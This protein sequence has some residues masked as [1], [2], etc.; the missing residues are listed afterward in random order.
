[1]TMK[2]TTL[3]IREPIGRAWRDEVVT[4]T[5]S[6]FPPRRKGLPLVVEA[7]TG[8]R[9]PAQWGEG[10]G[11][12]PELL[13]FIPELHAD[14]VKRLEWR[15]VVPAGLEDIPGAVFCREEADGR[16][17]MGGSAWMVELPTAQRPGPPI[18][19]FKG[20][21]GQWRGGGR[22]EQT[23]PLESLET[24]IV[25]SGPVQAEAQITWRWGGHKQLVCWVRTRMGI[26]AVE[27]EE[28]FAVAPA[29]A[30][31]LE[32]SREFSPD[33]VYL[34][35]HTGSIGRGENTLWEQSFPIDW[36]IPGPYRL[37][38]YH[39]WDLDGATWWACYD[40]KGGNDLVGLIMTRIGFWR[41]GLQNQ[42]LVET[43]PPAGV[44][45]RFPLGE[46]RRSWALF[47]GDRSRDISLGDPLKPGAVHRAQIKLS[48]LPLQKVLGWRLD[49]YDRRPLSEFPRIFLKPGQLAQQRRKARAS[50]VWTKFEKTTLAEIA[51]AKREKKNLDP[52]ELWGQE[53]IGLA[54]AGRTL[55][56]D[57]VAN[58]AEAMIRLMEDAV[59]RFLIRGYT[60]HH[61]VALCW[62]RYAR[63]LA[64][65]FDALAGIGAFSEDQLRRVLKCWNFVTHITGEEDYWPRE[66]TAFHRGNP[67]FH[68]DVISALGVMAGL[69]SDH[70]DAPAWRDFVASEFDKEFAIAI[71][72][73]GVWYES[74][75][76]SV[77]T[78]W[79]TT[80]GLAALRHTG[81][82]DLFKDPR[83]RRC[84]HALCDIMTP[85]DPRLKISTIPT[86][87]NSSI[88]ENSYLCLY[89]WLSAF[90][91]EDDPMLAGK[92]AETWRLAG[93]PVGHTNCARAITGL[94]LTLDVATP[95]PLTFSSRAMPE[96]G[97]LLRHGQTYLLYKHGPHYQHYDADEGS[98][99][100]FWKGTPLC[101][102]WG[103]QYTPNIGQ[104]WYH[105]RVALAHREEG[106]R[107]QT[108]WFRSYD[109][110]DYV[111]GR[112]VALT[113]RA[114]PET[115][116]EK[117]KI[118]W[119]RYPK[120]E[121]LPAPIAWTRH[122]ILVKGPDFLVIWDDFLGGDWSEW[123]LWT[124][125]ESCEFPA[126]NQAF[127]K[128][129][130]QVD[131]SVF[132]A[133]PTDGPLV[134]QR[135]GYRFAEPWSWWTETQ[136]LV[137][138]RAPNT[139]GF[140]TAVVPT[141]RRQPLPTFQSLDEGEAMNVTVDGRTFEIRITPEKP[142]KVQDL[143]DLHWLG[144]RRYLR[145]QE[146]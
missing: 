110:Y 104:P 136:Q 69:V 81:G 12:T 50:R 106:E 103:S 44:V 31:V 63:T 29:A 25:A 9:L 8:T 127:L 146:L 141:L 10:A 89:A 77:G 101:L 132:F 130:F 36:T 45:A 66:E 49:W 112:T 26:P 62:S 121:P 99:H 68:T 79:W 70:P 126:P 80:L 107:G 145:L 19:A 1:M 11:R 32:L 38:A 142:E 111:I 41:R 37:Q 59:D 137:R 124:M 128:G 113:S 46:G 122:L 53:E 94:Q 42:V 92:L 20:V 6:K 131:L 3:V 86:T 16:L 97:A 65:V 21:D 56:P 138:A 108:L 2:T 33:T 114:M 120:F 4:L 82:P 98:F 133:R 143:N 76:Y 7:R 28:S 74:P 88:V 140:F 129:Q 48:A 73:S 90:V 17:V 58:Y 139:T 71:G 13:V 115:P 5:S 105:N 67:N 57:V 93:S 91:K 109:R 27:V 15:G 116:E 14:E 125:A 117:V 24:R 134:T 135:Y 72:P 144:L 30:Y 47:L 95:R 39:M 35:R 75:L 34:R 102:D 84:M 55:K 64:M 52:M 78:I 18:L 119:Q 60:D 118:P 23:P 100:W 54:L 22:F 123:N 83:F 43:P 51:K 85:V 40:G 87:G 96:Y 61:N